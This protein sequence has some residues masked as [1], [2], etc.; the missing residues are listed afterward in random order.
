MM[1][2]DFQK[3]LPKFGEMN[4]IR[5]LSPMLFSHFFN[6]RGLLSDQNKTRKGIWNKIEE[7]DKS[8]ENIL[9]SDFQ[10][11]Q[12]EAFQHRLKFFSDKIT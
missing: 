10:N 7:H 4:L 2:D 11:V 3:K 9:V 12:K 1:P 8:L 5:N 6:F